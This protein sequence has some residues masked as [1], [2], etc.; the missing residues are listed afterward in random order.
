M[1]KETLIGLAFITANVI[2]WSLRWRMQ[3]S[4]TI[5]A[6][7]GCSGAATY[8]GLAGGIVGCIAAGILAILQGFEV[9][10]HNGG[11]GDRSNPVKRSSD[12][13]SIVNHN[14]EKVDSYAHLVPGK[15]GKVIIDNI[16]LS[17]IRYANNHTSLGYHFTL[18]GSGP[19]ARGEA[20][21]IWGV[22]ADEAIDKGTPSK[23]DLQNMSADLAKNGFKGHQG[24]ACSTVKDG[25]KDVYMIKFLLTGSSNDPGGSPC[26]DD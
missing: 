13:F 9:N 3:K 22:G 21:T 16:E 12:L 5:A 14:G 24:V 1:R 26:S 4:T 15:V 7:A 18:D 17:A 8:G 25:K 23:N 2:A 11:G 10:W 20:T 6:I 19:A